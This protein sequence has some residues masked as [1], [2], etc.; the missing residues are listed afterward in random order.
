VPPDP[1][2]DAPP[3]RPPGPGPRQPRAGRCWPSAG[4]PGGRGGLLLT[5]GG[6]EPPVADL[7]LSTWRVPSAELEAQARRRPGAAGRPR[8][9]AG[10]GRRSPR[11]WRPTTRSLARARHRRSWADWREA[12]VRLR[13][14]LQRYAGAYGIQRYHALGLHCATA[15]GGVLRGPRRGADLGRAAPGLGR[16]AAPRSGGG[17]LRRWAALPR[18]GAARRLVRP[19]ATLQEAPSTSRASS[20]SSPLVHW[21]EP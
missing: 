8:T 11:S 16:P 5:A 13:T 19:D 9:G 15:S 7:R 14:A 10:R 18:R 6:G 2:A 3:T 12:Q 1:T 17:R 21:I 4:R 20:S